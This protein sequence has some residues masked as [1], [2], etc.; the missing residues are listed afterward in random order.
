MA[1]PKPLT[2]ITANRL[3]VVKKMTVPALRYDAQSLR[4]FAGALLVGSGLATDRAS[5]VASVLVEADMMGHDT[6]GLNLL[7]NYLDHLE[8][9]D[10]A[11]SGDPIVE[12]DRP[13]AVS[14]DGCKLPG[15]WLVLRAMELAIARAREYGTGTVTIRRSHHIGC[16]AVYLKRATDQGMVM[17]LYSSSPSGGSVAPFGGRRALFSPS[18]M[19]MGCPTEGDPILVDISTSATTNNLLT[20]LQRQGKKLPHPLLLD[21]DGYPT[22]DP[23]AVM[24]PKKGSVLPLGG[25]DG[26]HKGYGLALMVEAL[27]AGLTNHGRHES[28]G[29]FVNTVFLQILDPEAF[30]GATGF[31]SQMSHIAQSCRDTLPRPGVDRVRVPGERGLA[32]ARGYAHDGVCL[33]D[34][35][36]QGLAPW[37][38]RLQVALPAS[39]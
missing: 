31:Q 10:M 17:K 35:I 26:G 19:A 14:W 4:N 7:P 12:S 13:A 15:A 29:K 34:G 23:A 2:S 38:Q 8:S 18:P 6:H 30:G 20:R 1:L 24:A 28:T 9:G 25:L 33:A 39:V 16:L 5:D 27:T 22:D 11:A 32:L 21:E 36:L 37:A 3:R